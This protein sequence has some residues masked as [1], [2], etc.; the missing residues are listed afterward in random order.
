MSPMWPRLV[1]SATAGEIHFSPCCGRLL[2]P[3]RANPLLRGI[4]LP[5]RSTECPTRSLPGSLRFPDSLADQSKLALDGKSRSQALAFD[6]HHRHLG[7]QFQALLSGLWR[8]EDDLHLK[9]AL[10]G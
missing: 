4:G 5:G 6:P 2:V 10:V 3:A 9:L 1:L 7:L 8:R